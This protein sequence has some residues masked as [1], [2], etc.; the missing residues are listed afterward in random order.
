MMKYENTLE[1]A[2]QA[3]TSDPLRYIR[4]KFVIPEKEGKALT[5]FLGNSL[6]LQPRT[7]HM[8]LQRIMQDWATLGVESFFHAPEPWMDYH[9]FFVNTLAQVTG[10]KPQEVVVMNQLTVNLHLMLVSFYRPAGKRYKIICEAKAFPSDQ[11]AFETHVRHH[12][13]DPAVAIIEVNP[14]AGEHT[15]RTE[16]ILKTIAEHGEE[17]VL[18]LFSG[19][20]YYTG[21]AFELIF[22]LPVATPGYR[23]LE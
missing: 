12:G 13:F 9:D 7:A 14:R 2:R 10:A 5:Y 3:D 11:Y 17:T 21:Q 23:W 16:D 4:Q 6:G 19:I 20:N 8:Y 22:H 18:V 1:F 15:L